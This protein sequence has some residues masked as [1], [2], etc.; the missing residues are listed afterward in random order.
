MSGKPLTLANCLVS[1]GC[2]PIVCYA[3]GACIHQSR[4][5]EDIQQLYNAVQLQKNN[6][7]ALYFEDGY[8]FAVHWFAL[9]HARKNLL[10]AANNTASQSITAESDHGRYQL[11]CA[12]LD[13]INHGIGHSAC[14]LK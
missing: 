2:D 6:D 8:R 3:D 13:F 7:F 10:I 5:C 11:R 14:A 4:F 1:D 9:L 12:G